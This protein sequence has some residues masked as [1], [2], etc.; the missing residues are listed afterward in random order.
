MK[1]LLALLGISYHDAPGEAEAEC[2][3]L[4]QQGVVD[5]VLS[6]DVDTL[7]FGCGL[8]LRNWSSEGA[9]GNKTPTHVSMFDAEKL[10][11]SSAGLSPRGMLLVAL[12]SGGDYDPAGLPGCGVK[13]ACEAARAGFGESL[14]RLSTSDVDGLRAWRE[15]LSHELQTNESRYFKVKH[16]NLQLPSDFPDRAILGF[17]LQPTV[18]SKI[19]VERLKAEI[20]WNTGIDVRRLRD[21]VATAF[22]WRRRSG[23]IKFVRGISEPLL[24]HSLLQDDP[25][26]SSDP[27]RKGHRRE[28][29][30]KSIEG[31]RIS[32]AGDGLPELCITYLPLG[33]MAEISLDAEESDDGSGLP[34]QGGRSGTSSRSTS[35]HE[36]VD[37]AEAEDN[38]AERRQR[39]ITGFD[40][41]QPQRLWISEKL[42][43]RGAPAVVQAWE[44][45]QRQLDERR[46][47]LAKLASEKAAAKV[48]KGRGGM[49]R[50]AMDAF[51]QISKP[52]ATQSR[53]RTVV[54]DKDAGLPVLDFLAPSPQG[55]R[56]PKGMPSKT[57]TATATAPARVGARPD[58]SRSR[59]RPTDSSTRK[60]QPESSDSVNPWALSKRPADTL[61]FKLPPGSRFP[62]LGLYGPSIDGDSGARPG[63]GPKASSVAPLLQSSPSKWNGR[64]PSPSLTWA[65]ESDSALPPSPPWLRPDDVCDRAA[66][67]DQGRGRGEPTVSVVGPSMP[68]V[69]DGHSTIIKDH[70]PKTIILI[71]SSPVAPAAVPVPSTSV[72]RS[73][74]SKSITS[75]LSVRTTATTEASS[76]A[77]NPV[78][79]GRTVMLRDSLDGAWRDTTPDSRRGDDHYRRA[80]KGVEVVDLT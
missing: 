25:E 40:P 13:V 39:G 78:K 36:E 38:K 17:Y 58:A 62:A 63:P 32:L 10:K 51:V 29:Q 56:A 71:S 14:C 21:F 22:D 57:A 46:Q 47:D 76:K 48:R 20:K 41:G 12:M 45:R 1:Q 55:I 37:D 59:H 18:S 67:R 65:N 7:M 4:Q 68:A 16:Q 15:G 5:A 54:R 23:T 74:V 42:L 19:Q 44:V 3:L 28:M 43:R 60:V 11:D 80:W 70:R 69:D 75:R 73:R 34:G 77:A 2:A 33:L 52:T 66:L 49:N 53:A 31:R 30:V 27:S 9:R 6:E 8:T 24:N 79:V 35:V 26:R 64:S 72:S 50:G 61:D